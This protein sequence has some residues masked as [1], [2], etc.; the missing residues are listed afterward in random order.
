MVGL[1]NNAG[2]TV[3]LN[4]MV[5]G[6]VSETTPT[7]GLNMDVVSYNNVEFL[8]FDVAGREEYAPFL[9]LPFPG[10]RGMIFVVDATDDRRL[11]L[12]RTQFQTCVSALPPEAPNRR[13]CQQARPP[14]CHLFSRN[15]R[16]PTP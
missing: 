8:L 1:D 7:A 10:S 6:E 3:I 15:R 9:L 11:D 12:A 13:F 2:K 4:K 14:Q 16:S 5:T